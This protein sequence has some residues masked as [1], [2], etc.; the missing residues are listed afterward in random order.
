MINNRAAYVGKL[1]AFVMKIPVPL[2]LI[3]LFFYSYPVFA[4]LLTGLAIWMVH[5]VK[6]TVEDEKQLKKLMN[7]IDSKAKS[8]SG[9]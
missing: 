9:G 1:I 7:M 6:V 4:L 3:C 5:L 2:A 8:G